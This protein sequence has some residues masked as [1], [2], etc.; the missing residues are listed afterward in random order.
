MPYFSSGVSAR[1]IA[2]EVNKPRRREAAGKKIRTGLA[3]ISPR[4]AFDECAP[5][6]IT[7]P[8]RRAASLMSVLKAT[9]IT[10][11]PKHNT[12]PIPMNWVHVV[13]LGTR[14]GW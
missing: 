13:G 5:A 8:A 1:R 10:E 2:V 12:D 6:A 7:A 14:S 9:V 4:V 3:R 11:T